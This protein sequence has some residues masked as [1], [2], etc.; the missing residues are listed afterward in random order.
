V[1]IALHGFN[2][3]SVFINDLAEALTQQ[4]ILVYAY[5]QRGFG[6]APH[7]GIWAGTEAMQRDLRT[8]TGIIRDRYPSTPIYL[9]G[10]SMGGALILLTLSQAPELS[11][12]GAILSAP[13]VWDGSTW[14]WYQR[15]ALWF[16]AHILPWLRVSGEGLD[17]IASDN[18]VM[19]RELGERDEIIPLEA[20][21][22]MVAA[23][24]VEHSGDQKVA[25][26]NDGYHMLTRDL[27]AA[28]VWKDIVSWINSP[29]SSLPSGADIEARKRLL[30]LS[31]CDY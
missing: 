10:E 11:I 1:V 15:A 30:G 12:E 3:H 29:D 21:G 14:P 2:D 5:D 6:A 13:A 17:I 27:Q 28:Q 18:N 7:A 8:F 22:K 23:L 20:T 25:L 4:S 19:L 26:Y 16:G 31:G 24:P 9:L